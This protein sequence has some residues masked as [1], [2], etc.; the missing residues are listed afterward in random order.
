MK[1]LI[2][3]ANKDS[4]ADIICNAGKNIFLRM[5]YFDGVPKDEESITKILI[6]HDQS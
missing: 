4:G 6:C 3:L 2:I 5:Q 1:N